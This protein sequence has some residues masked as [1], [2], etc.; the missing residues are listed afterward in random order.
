MDVGNFLAAIARAR[1]ANVNPRGPTLF[2]ER[3]ALTE[4]T[5][6]PDRKVG[7][8]AAHVQVV[9]TGVAKGRRGR[10]CA[11]SQHPGHLGKPWWLV[12][13]QDESPSNEPRK[14]HHPLNLMERICS[15]LFHR[16]AV[17]NRKDR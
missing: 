10:L 7:V 14:E 9:P 8:A 1:M 11:A 5:P 16:A 3:K 15:F 17:T 6:P 4:S 2:M 13:F 12:L